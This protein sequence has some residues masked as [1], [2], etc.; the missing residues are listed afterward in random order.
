M[1]RYECAKRVSIIGIIA[2]LFLFVIKIAVA[3][4]SKSQGL[5]ADATNSGSDVFNSI[6]TYIGN[7]LSSKPNDKEH[8]YGHGKIEYVFSMIIS[9]SMF[10]LAINILK[11]SITAIIT[12]QIIVFSMSLVYVCII[13]I[14][15]K[16]LLYIYTINVGKK[17]ENLLIVAASQD[18][19]NDVFVTITT[20]L[21]I[22]GYKLGIYYLD[23]IV[24]II[25]SFW[26]V[27]VSIKIFLSAYEVL[28]DTD[29]SDDI[30][31]EITNSIEEMAACRVDSIKA[32]PVGINYTL[33]LE[34][35]LK[36]EISLEDGHK[37]AENIKLK[38]CE[39]DKIIDVI[40][41]VNPKTEI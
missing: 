4:A 40:V 5:L 13:T 25:I 34:I 1:D 18:H 16:I 33:L 28:I 22:I 35:T 17:H 2:N 38:T 12:K 31:K 41:H 6:I 21:G 36:Y 27:F 8:P 9:I 14:I 23:G 15:V 24:G 3:F 7:R 29:I 10:L 20:L 11:D 30:K 37:I 32:I 19:R 39:I 26:I